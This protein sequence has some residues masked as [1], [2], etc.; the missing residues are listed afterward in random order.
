MSD[1]IVIYINDP[2]NAKHEVERSLDDRLYNLCDE[3]KQ[4]IGKKD[5]QRITEIC[6]IIKNLITYKVKLEKENEQI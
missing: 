3:L 6:N 4:L 5:I 1:K 2:I